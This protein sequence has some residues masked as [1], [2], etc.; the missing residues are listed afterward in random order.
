[1]LT[2]SVRIIQAPNYEVPR[3]DKQS[4]I[5]MVRD[6]GTCIGPES[7]FPLPFSPK[8]LTT[9]ERNVA[10]AVDVCH[11]DPGHRARSSR[12]VLR[13]NKWNYGY[14]VFELK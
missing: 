14:R 2:R 8:K 3:D 4:L 11:R 10:F 12:S 13:R 7:M 1:M 9:C 6:I 5:R